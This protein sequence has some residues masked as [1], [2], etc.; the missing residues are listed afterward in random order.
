MT[1]TL[2]DLALFKNNDWI[3]TVFL[4]WPTE[5]QTQERPYTKADAD[6]EGMPEVFLSRTDNLDAELG[7]A[8]SPSDFEVTVTPQGGTATDGDWALFLDA[9]AI[10]ADNC[11]G[12]FVDGKV[13]VHIKVTAGS[14]QVLEIA[15]EP[16]RF[17]TTL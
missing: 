16:K 8:D 11:D 13:Y 4:Y 2:S 10:T 17:A 14:H 15:Y 5:D 9:S 3:P 1:T 7:D 6:S 12:F